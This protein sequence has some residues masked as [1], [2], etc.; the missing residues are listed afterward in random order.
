M[1]GT[2]D[3]LIEA[4]ARLLDKGGPA[5]VTLRAVADRC[6]VS[7]NA[8]YKHFASKAELLAAIASR[9]LTGQPDTAGSRRGDA[10]RDCGS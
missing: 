5:A 8:P 7:H 2:R 3:R 4:A 10:W 9:E 6:G 1:T